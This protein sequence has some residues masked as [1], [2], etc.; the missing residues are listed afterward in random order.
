[1]F[2][3]LFCFQ[4]IKCSLANSLITPKKWNAN[5]QN[6]VRPILIGKSC[7]LTILNILM[8]VMPYFAVDV[9]LLNSGKFC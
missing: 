3:K 4:A 5:I 1:M 7:S 2:Q 6:I 8:D 9:S